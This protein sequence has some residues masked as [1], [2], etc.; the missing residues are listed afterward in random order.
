MSRGVHRGI[1]WAPLADR[2]VA[3]GRP[4]SPL[5]RGSSTNTDPPARP[6]HGSV[7]DAPI[8]IE[9]RGARPFRSSGRSDVRGVVLRSACSRGKPVPNPPGHHAV[10]VAAPKRTPHLQS[11]ET[12]LVLDEPR[13]VPVS[14]T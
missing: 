11:A 8:A 7:G 2:P 13:P 4:R 6:D 1:T 9:S 3:T 12:R 14:Y 10:R 5:R